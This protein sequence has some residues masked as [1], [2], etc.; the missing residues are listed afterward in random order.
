MGSATARWLA[1]QGRHVV[2]LEQF[3]RGHSRGGSHGDSRIFRLAYPDDTYTG[4]AVDSLAMW[5]DLEESC[6]RQILTITGGVDHGRGVLDSIGAVLGGRGVPFEVM[7]PA[8]AGDRWPGMLFDREVVFQ[9][10]AGR[11]H[12]DNA[13]DAFQDLAE[14]AG[15]EFVFD[16]KA[17]L[18]RV[19]HDSVIV[20]TPSGDIEADVAVVTAGPWTPAVA[21]EMELPPFLVTHEEPAYFPSSSASEGWPVFLHYEAEAGTFAAYG[22]AVPGRGVKVGMHASGDLVEPDAEHRRV[23]PRVATT[24]ADYVASWLPGLEPTPTDTVSCI[25]DTT[26]REEFVIDRRGPLV[27]AG[28]FSG[29]GFKFAPAIGRMVGRLASGLGDPPTRFRFRSN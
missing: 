3:G 12:A 16:A 1:G 13:V 18:A 23:S 14:K 5:R 21:S 7:A 19:G 27:V 2:V 8:A 20:T 10:E 22:M 6:D 17:E 15:A 11:L 4:L 9:P 26:P 24:L 29:H 28:G 25:Y